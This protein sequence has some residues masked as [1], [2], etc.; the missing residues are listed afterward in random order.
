MDSWTKIQSLNLLWFH[1]I[2]LLNL[3]FAF[4][5]WHTEVKIRQWNHTFTLWHALAL[6]TCCSIKRT[7]DK[8]EF[9]INGS[10]IDM[11]AFGKSTIY[12]SARS[13]G[14]SIRTV[15]NNGF[16]NYENGNHQWLKVRHSIIYGFL[17][18]FGLTLFVLCKNPLTVNWSSYINAFVWVSIGGMIS[19]QML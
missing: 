17:V 1:F 18:M 2:L 5:I 6:Q 19:C 8:F 14:S 13:R 11:A 3:D 4:W 9:E 12:G 10:Q 16:R 7:A 15:A